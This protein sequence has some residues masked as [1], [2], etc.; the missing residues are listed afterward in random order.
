[1]PQHVRKITAKLHFTNAAKTDHHVKTGPKKAPKWDS[2]FPGIG[3]KCFDIW[4]WV[5]NCSQET[6]RTPIWPPRSPKEPKNDPTMTLRCLLRVSRL[7]QNWAAVLKQTKGLAKLTPFLL[8]ANSHLS[9]SQPTLLAVRLSCVCLVVLGCVCV[10]ACCSVL[11]AP[12]YRKLQIHCG[13]WTVYQIG[14]AILFITFQFLKSFQKD[15]G[16]QIV[17]HV[18]HYP[19]LFSCNIKQEMLRAC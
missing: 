13:Y 5:P 6:P 1:M 9:Q 11:S 15:T 16:I 19:I 4:I 3:P 7:D 18:L 12:W 14:A 2:Y 10:C 17:F 8:Q